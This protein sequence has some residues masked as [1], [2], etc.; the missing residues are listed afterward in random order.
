VYRVVKWRGICGGGSDVRVQLSRIELELI[1]RQRWE[2][3]IEVGRGLAVARALGLAIWHAWWTGEGI[4]GGHTVG[5]RGA[6]SVARV[7]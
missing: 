7:L 6:A 2:R 4:E 3:R 5:G 1:W